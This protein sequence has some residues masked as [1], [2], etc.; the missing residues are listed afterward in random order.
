M[1]KWMPTEEACDFQTNSPGQNGK[2]C[3]G[4][5]WR[6]YI[7]MSWCK[8]SKENKGENDTGIVC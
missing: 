6:K 4:A 8:R 3:M 7:L 2:K 5:V 1:A